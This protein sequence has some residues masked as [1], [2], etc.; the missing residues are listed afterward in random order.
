MKPPKSSFFNFFGVHSAR[1]RAQTMPY[2]PMSTLWAWVASMMAH[3]PRR[4]GALHFPIFRSPV[5]RSTFRISSGFTNWKPLENARRGKPLESRKM[6][7][8]GHPFS[9]FPAVLT[10]R[11]SGSFRGRGK[12]HFPQ[13]PAAGLGR[14]PEVKNEDTFR[15]KPRRK[16]EPS[17]F[18]FSL[19]L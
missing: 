8:R 6:G 4:H 18:R 9:D 1:G 10:F 3:L 13:S 5:S 16:M 15:P 12:G 2:I 14:C 11:L 19:T 7:P 17:F